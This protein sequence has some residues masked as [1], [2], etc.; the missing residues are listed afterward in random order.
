M[1]LYTKLALVNTISKALIFSAFVLFVPLMVRQVVFHHTDQRL[2]VM[3]ERLIRIINRVGV[4]TF[5]KSEGDTTFSSYNILKEEYISLEPIP[6]TT[7]F[8]EKIENAQRNIEN[9]IVDYRV[10]SFV[11][12]KEKKKY[13]LEI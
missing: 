8:S 2:H 13:L 3:K 7:A 1:R 12:E 9:V 5:I 10:L 6:D 4:N 11:F